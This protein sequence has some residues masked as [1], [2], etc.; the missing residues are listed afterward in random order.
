MKKSAHTAVAVS[1]IAGAVI[2]LVPTATAA[3]SNSGSAQ[4][5]VNRLQALG[6]HVALNGSETAPLSQ[7]I[8]TAVH[9]SDPGNAVTTEL[10]TVWV[11]ISCPP[12]NN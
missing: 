7:C 8:V 2:G 3:P 11:D 1:A 10:S 6:Y 12:T 4:D 9:P 5:T